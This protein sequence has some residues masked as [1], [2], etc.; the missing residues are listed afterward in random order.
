MQSHDIKQAID[1]ANAQA[2]FGK[3]VL[4]LNGHGHRDLSERFHQV[5]YV[6]IPTAA[7]KWDGKPIPYTTVRFAIVTLDAKGTIEIDAHSIE[8]EYQN[9]GQGESAVGDFTAKS[10]KFTP[11]PKRVKTAPAPR[12]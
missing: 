11:N 9:K 3:F 6:E 12:P 1:Q 2:G 5:P 4:S 10:F 8:F 7:H